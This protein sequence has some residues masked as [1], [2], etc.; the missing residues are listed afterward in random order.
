MIEY[1][2]EQEIK[3]IVS[4]KIDRACRGYKSAYLLEELMNEFDMKLHFTRENLVVD[5]KS[6]MSVKDR[7]GI[8]IWLGKKYTNNLR[9]EVMKGMSEREPRGFW[10][11]KAPIGYLNVR[12]KGRAF[13]ELD[14]DTYPHIQ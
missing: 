12:K 14:N 11:F 4:D 13:I 5:K 2:K 8:G 1:V 9:I 3:N 10:N 7:L 6:P